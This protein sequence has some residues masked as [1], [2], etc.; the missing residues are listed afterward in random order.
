MKDTISKRLT[1]IK[2]RTLGQMTGVVSEKTARNYELK[3]H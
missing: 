2:G 1:G 3:K